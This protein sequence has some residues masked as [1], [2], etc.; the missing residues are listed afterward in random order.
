MKKLYTLNTVNNF[1]EMIYLPF[2]VPFL[3]KNVDVEIINIMDDSLL[4]ETR[5]SGKVTAEVCSKMLMY[6][7]TAEA[8]GADGILTTCTS[9]NQATKQIKSFLNIPMINIEE[10]V[11]ELAVKNGRK[12]GIIGTIPTS[13]L[14]MDYIIRE[15][16]EELDKEVAISHFVVEDAFDI[17]C[18]GDRR[19]H[20]AMINEMIQEVEKL[21]D[22]IVFSQISMSLVPIDKVSAPLYKIGTSGFEKI[23]SMMK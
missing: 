12:I 16:A 8:A 19:K 11:A 2:G 5:K 14:A 15:K 17:L 9:V 18:A 7:K 13:P 4:S 23:Y 22:V 20:D 10:P 6:A 21:V 1:M 3:E